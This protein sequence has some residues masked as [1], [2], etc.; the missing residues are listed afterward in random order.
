MNTAQNVFTVTSSDLAS[1]NS[2]QISAPSGSTVI[3]N[4]SGTSGQIE[5][6]GISLSGV[7]ASRVVFNFW[8]ATS[9]ALSSTSVP[10]TV[11]SPNATVTLSN[12]N[13]NGS[14]VAQSLSVSS[15]SVT[16]S[17]FTGALPR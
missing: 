3:V 16:Y 1:A 15:A 9:L 6:A 10:G 7:S 5:N 11:W 2:V 17:A 4:V 14:V 12:G 13:V 8:Q